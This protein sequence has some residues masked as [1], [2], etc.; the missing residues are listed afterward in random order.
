MYKPKIT[1]SPRKISNV[2]ILL[3]KKI[4]SIKDVKKA[5]VLIVTNATDTLETLIALKKNIQ[6]IAIMIPENKNFKSPFLFT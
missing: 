2:F 4:G 5:P 6:C 1:K 3:L